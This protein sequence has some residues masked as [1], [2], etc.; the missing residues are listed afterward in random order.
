M[1]T[2]RFKRVYSPG[3]DGRR[4]LWYNGRVPR[5]TG[6]KERN[7]DL[8]MRKMMA[9]LM[10][11]MMLM[12]LCPAVAEDALLEY[13]TV[14]FRPVDC[15]VQ[16]QEQYVYPF[17]GM[18]AVL[19]PTMLDKIDSRE[20][21]VCTDEDY[22]EEGQIR[23]A[24]MRFSTTTEEDR[25]LE[26]MSVDFYA[27]EEALKRLGAL[28]V[29]TKDTEAELD[30]LTGCDVH[31]KLGE[32]ADGA[33]VYYLSASSKGD[34]TLRDELAETVVTITEMHVLDMEMGY[35]A[36]STDRLEDVNS[37]E[38]FA[39]EDVFGNSYDE[40]YFQQYDLTL[41]NVF[42]TW[43]SPCVQEMP[44]LEALRKAYEEKGVKLG[45]VGMV[46][47]TKIT[48]GE[49]STLDE[50]AVARAKV[51]HERSGVQFPFLIPDD[52]NMNGRLT[53]IE[54]VPESFFVDS[55]GRIVSD[56]YVGARSME[57]WSQI[58]DAEL[59]KLGSAQ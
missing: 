1:F 41:V 52:G 12:A 19:S 43:C 22:T 23:Y 25:A 13:E 33:Y 30:A 50:G 40:T 8:M 11:L 49:K 57:S 5:K 31:Q 10:A 53:G 45:V 36:F 7:E 17:M 54:S 39:T 20:V 3:V 29:Y 26:T 34:Q 46:L 28:G 59:A 44:E 58:V 42:A 32:S 37:V 35:T 21:F 38:P 16:A 55:E 2:V 56:L 47:D 18:T 14:A 51:L 15:G 9:L 6:L 48:L 27:W 4:R 24:L